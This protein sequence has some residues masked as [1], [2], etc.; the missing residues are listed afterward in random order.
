M[1]T[2]THSSIKKMR[3]VSIP[4]SLK[5]I[6]KVLLE[7]FG[8]EKLSDQNLAGSVRTMP[9]RDIGKLLLE[10]GNTSAHRAKVL[11]DNIQP[12]APPPYPPLSQVTKPNLTTK[13][14][15]YYSDMAEQT[16]RVKA[17]Y[18]TFPDGLRPLRV[19]GK[20]AWP[21]A[22]AKKLLGVA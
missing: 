6:V 9:P 18:E 14:L 5:P 3:D 11:H 7:H 2:A 17:C 4:K 16:W 20:L 8:T 10:L 19:C 21:T 15:A 1:Q 13:E 22:G 12:Q